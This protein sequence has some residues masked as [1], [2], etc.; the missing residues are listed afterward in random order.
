MAHTREVAQCTDGFEYDDANVGA[1]RVGR[2]HDETENE[3]EDA[4]RPAASRMTGRPRAGATL[5]TPAATLEATTDLTFTTP[6]V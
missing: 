3:E 5:A 1:A 4:A 2:R 6:I